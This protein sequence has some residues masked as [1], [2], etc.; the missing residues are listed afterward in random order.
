VRVL[1]I[2]DELDIPIREGI[3]RIVTRIE[4]VCYCGW[5]GP[6]GEARVYRVEAHGDGKPLT[7]TPL[8]HHVIHS[9]A[10]FA[11]GYGGSG[12][13]DLAYNL[14]LD[15]L[16][17]RLSTEPRAREVAAKTWA[18][19]TSPVQSRHAQVHDL[20]AH[21]ASE[22]YQDV[23]RALVAALPERWLLPGRVLRDALRSVLMQARRSRGWVTPVS[24]D[25]LELAVGDKERGPRKAAAR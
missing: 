2:P 25:A 5:H 20:A 3:L 13:A 6:E 21:V 23:K 15:Y 11:W 14:L 22:L 4:P 16:R 1:L 17:W 12:P 8:E 9:P 10:G 18:F 7:A 19:S 24:R